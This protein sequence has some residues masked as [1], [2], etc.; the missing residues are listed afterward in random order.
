MRRQL[1][2][3]TYKL[4]PC[5][6]K[7]AVGSDRREQLQCLTHKKGF[8]MNVDST[9]K[10]RRHIDLEGEE[11]ETTQA[12]FIRHMLGQMSKLSTTASDGQVLLP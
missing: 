5:R 3:Q 2:S 1:G 8:S 10:Y 12:S 7:R 11:D 6:R 4:G 9:S